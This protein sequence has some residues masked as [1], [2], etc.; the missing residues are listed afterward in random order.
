MREWIR[1]CSTD[2]LE[3]D[4]VLGV[5]AGGRALA[6]YRSE[7]DEWF[8]TDGYCTHE[9]APLCD[10]FVMDGIIECPRHN[11]RFDY[12]T[13]EALSAPALVDLK[14][15]PVIVRDGHVHVAIGD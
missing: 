9:A 10:G 5:D 15:Y 6:I 14:T 11:G 4:D 7:S 13:G 1:V 12:R 2:A 3:P 8:A